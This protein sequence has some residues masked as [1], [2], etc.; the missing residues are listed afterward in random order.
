MKVTYFH[1]K[2]LPGM[3]SIERLFMDIRS[4]LS[5]MVQYRVSVAR[6]HSRKYWGRLYNMLE[7]PWRQSDVNHV[8]GD[9]HYLTICLRKKTTLLTIHDCI[10]LERMKGVKKV[11]NFFLWYWLPIRR[12]TLISVV[13]ESTKRQ[14]LKYLKCDPDKIRVVHDCVSNIFQPS[15][16]LYNS[17][18]PVILQM[19][20]NENKNLLRLTEA[21]EDIPC[22]LHIIGE[23]SPDQV[24]ALHRHKI[25]YTNENGISD[26]D[27]VERYRRCDMVAFVSTY[28]GFGLPILEANATGRPVI[29]SNILSMP[30]VAGDAA[31]LV[32]PFD[33][34]SIRRGILRV[35][36]DADYRENLVQNGFKNVL[37]FQP[38]AIAAQYVRLYEELISQNAV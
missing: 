3:Y 34:E 28:E 26:Q 37:R 9:V 38:H 20:A 30:E 29:T 11:I 32:D 21:L 13:S 4:A 15:P 18:R 7:A 36:Q 14:L 17:H 23:L 33:I 2:P 27:L 31:C 12:S 6:F 24:G 35:M 16:Y 8:T 19:G 1:R 25:D 10:P 22:H 5:Q